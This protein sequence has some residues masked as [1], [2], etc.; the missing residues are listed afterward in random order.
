M[1]L[2]SYSRPL[3]VFTI[4]WSRGSRLI[5]YYGLLNFMIQHNPNLVHNKVMLSTRIADDNRQLKQQSSSVGHSK[6]RRTKRNLKK[7]R[8]H[9]KFDSVQLIKNPKRSSLLEKVLHKLYFVSHLF[10]IYLIRHHFKL[11]VFFHCW[12]M[13]FLYAICSHIDQSDK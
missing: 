5:F 13:V 12:S 11:G 2:K 9:P 3:G 8:K 6:E 10:Y 7:N 4:I 1:Q